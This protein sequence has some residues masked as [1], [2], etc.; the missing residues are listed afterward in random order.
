MNISQPSTAFP[1]SLSNLSNLSLGFISWNFDTQVYP[2][3]EAISRQ[4]FHDLF[5]HLGISVG[6]RKE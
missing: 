4:S 5:G 3:L 1:N 6:V 2:D